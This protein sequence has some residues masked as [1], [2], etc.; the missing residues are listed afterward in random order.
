MILLLF[1]NCFLV[2]ITQPALIKGEPSVVIVFAVVDGAGHQCVVVVGV[3]VVGVD[4]VVA[5]VV[6]AVVV[7]FVVVVAIVVVA[8]DLPAEFVS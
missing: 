5:V 6:V 8:K 7:V 1:T 3:D 2:F 4:V